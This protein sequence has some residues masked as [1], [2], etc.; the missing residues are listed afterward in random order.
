MFSFLLSRVVCMNDIFL[1]ESDVT[2]KY[3]YCWK[4]QLSSSN[5]CGSNFHL[6]ATKRL[7][8]DHTDSISCHRY[9]RCSAS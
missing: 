9:D 3:I 1:C 5:W 7:E 8:K 2:K 6:L 4:P